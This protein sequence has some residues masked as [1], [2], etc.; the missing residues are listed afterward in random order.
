[1]DTL[2]D[3]FARDREGSATSEWMRGFAKL[4]R[5][6]QETVRVQSLIDQEFEIIEPED[7]R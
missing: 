3:K 1:M 6:H 5:L 4:K 2:H 7:R